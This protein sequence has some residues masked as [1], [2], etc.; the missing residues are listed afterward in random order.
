[1]LDD[2]NAPRLTLDPE[3]GEVSHRCGLAPDHTGR[4]VCF[5]C[6]HGWEA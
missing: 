2:C 3:A 4:H 1:M 5:Y 6:G